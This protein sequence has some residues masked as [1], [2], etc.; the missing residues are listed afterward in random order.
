[1]PDAEGTARARTA[2]EYRARLFVHGAG[3]SSHHSGL[4]GLMDSLFEKRRRVSVGVDDAHLAAKHIDQLRQR[5]DTAVS[6][7]S[8]ELGCL[9]GPDRHPAFWIGHHCA[10]FQHLKTAPPASDA[11][12]PLQ[13][14]TRSLPLDR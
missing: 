3:L 8:P 7:K 5:V 4:G 12:L 14:R 11:A 6:K 2:A 13:N 1:M 10:E 9:A